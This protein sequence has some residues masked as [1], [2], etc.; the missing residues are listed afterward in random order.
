MI[1]VGKP[2]RAKNYEQNQFHIIYSSLYYIFINIYYLYYYVLDYILE[3]IY[4]IYVVRRS[5][6]MEEQITNTKRQSSHHDT[7]ILN[8]TKT[9][10]HKFVDR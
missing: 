2:T 6:N 4:H 8:S 10:H 3:Y 5:R 1:L 9:K 7:A